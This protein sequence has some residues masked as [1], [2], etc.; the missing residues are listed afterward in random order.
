MPEPFFKILD[1][2][3]SKLS[4]FDRLS[5]M[6]FTGRLTF[7][8]LVYANSRCGLNNVEKEPYR[9]NDYYFKNLKRLI[10]ENNYK[11]HA[12]F[13]NEYEDY[14]NYNKPY[15][16]K[17]LLEPLTDQQ[18]NFILEYIKNNRIFEYVIEKGDIVRLKTGI[19]SIKVTSINGSKRYKN[20]LIY[21]KY[22]K[23]HHTID[24]RTSN[25]FVIIKKYYDQHD[26]N[27]YENQTTTSNQEKENKM[28]KL[29]KTK[30]DKYGTQIATDS[31][32]QFVL[33]MKDGSGVKAFSKKDLE[34]VR[35][36]TFSIRYNN[37]ATSYHYIGTK[38]C[39]K[40][41]DVLIGGTDGVSIGIVN[42]VDTNSDQAKKEFKGRKVMTET[43]DAS[44]VSGADT[45]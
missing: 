8:H 42:N 24:G 3:C 10:S 40:L 36:W 35:P 21:G 1:Q 41:G 44:I 23:T 5:V 38:D 32:G 12:H 20:I 33:E 14:L 16:F 22:C 4:Y 37:C 2:T 26:D 28:N 6:L 31:Q 15:S 25:D 19:A 43:L 34:E 45:A 29:F 13:I 30:D 27:D 17:C 9:I 18:Y 7:S 11:K 39:V